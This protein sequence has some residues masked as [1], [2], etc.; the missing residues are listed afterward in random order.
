M[1]SA[2]TTSDEPSAGNC[3]AH[4]EGWQRHTFSRDKQIA[5]T[6]ESVT[7]ATLK[8]PARRLILAG[9]FAVAIAAAPAVA[10]VAVPTNSAPTIA[11]CPGG[12]SEDTFTGVCTPDLVPNSP[13]PWLK[14]RPVGCRRWTTSHAPEPIPASASVCPRSSKPEGPDS[15][16]RTRRSA[17][18]RSRMPK[19]SWGAAMCPSFFVCAADTFPANTENVCRLLSA[20][21]QSCQRVGQRRQKATQ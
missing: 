15:R 18:A 16:C 20:F 9:G 19:Q 21:V 14:R 6:T 1:A 8:L 12:E 13:E 10:V 7:M 11:A 5:R 2:A 3:R 17:R 4:A